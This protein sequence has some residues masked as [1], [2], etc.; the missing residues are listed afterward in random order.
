MAT[1]IQA[2]LESFLEGLHDIV[3]HKYLKIFD[4]K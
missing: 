2:Q 3:P 4:P 1:A